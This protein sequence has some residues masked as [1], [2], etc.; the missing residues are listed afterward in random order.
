MTRYE[1]LTE[2]ARALVD[3][4]VDEMS[5]KSWIERRFL[6]TRVLQVE[7]AALSLKAEIDDGRADGQG[8]TPSVGVIAQLLA[9]ALDRL[10]AD[11]AVC[12]DSALVLSISADRRHREAAQKWFASH[13]GAWE[14]LQP[15]VH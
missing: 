12:S 14:E 8:S 11:E 15:T 5:G 2:E 7:Q 6:V 13:P 9:L 4:L 3:D 10:D 1:T